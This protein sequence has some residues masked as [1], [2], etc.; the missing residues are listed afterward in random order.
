MPMMHSGT[1]THVSHIHE[2]S[3][4]SHAEND[5]HT[6]A[7]LLDRKDIFVFPFS[8]AP[9]SAN[10]SGSVNFSKVSHAKLDLLVSGMHNMTDGAGTAVTSAVTDDYQVDVYGVNYNWLALK[11][12]RG[13]ISFA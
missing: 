9:E 3:M 2:T 12:G 5:F 10:P 6:M 8:L 11:D 1:N 4:T 7:E 13:H